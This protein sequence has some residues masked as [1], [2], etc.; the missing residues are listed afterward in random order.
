MQ[1]GICLLSVIPLRAAAESKS[2][3]VSQLLF[4][5]TYE[6]LAQNHNWIQIKTHADAYEAWISANQYNSWDGEMG[7]NLVSPIFPYLTVTNLSNNS[8]FHLLP[9]SVIPNAI[10]SEAQINF[11]INDVH[12]QAVLEGGAIQAIPTNDLIHFAKLFLNSPYL[13]GGRSFMGIDC[14]GFTQLIYKVAGIQIP[15][16]AY[17]QAGIG[18]DVSFVNEALPGDLAFF[19]NAEGRITHVG[20]ICG[21]GEI[22][23]ASGM[24]RIDVLDSYGIFNEKLGTHTHKLRIIKRLLN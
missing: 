17:Q 1:K 19:D 18:E 20:M 8:T 9:G 4:G 16:D 14:S 13:W 21:N 15:R 10:V 5:E 11:Q 3:M 23:H 7:L 6:V 22:I 24:V 2:E 12:Y